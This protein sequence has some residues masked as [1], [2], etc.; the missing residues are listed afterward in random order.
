MKHLSAISLFVE[1]LPAAKAFYVEVFEVPVVYEDANSA[2]VKFD[3][4]LINLLQ[5]AHAPEIV[6]PGP[7]ASREAGSRFQISIWVPDVDAVCAQLKQRGVTLL[8]GPLDRP[9]GMRTANFV[10][11]A[12]HSW[13]VA[14]QING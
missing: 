3:N 14:Q 8:Q 6:A 9:W 7:V 4:L 5:V 10:D 11:P 12:G 13:E 1:D 2:V